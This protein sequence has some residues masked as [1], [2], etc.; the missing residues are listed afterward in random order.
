MV[1]SLKSFN[2]LNSSYSK[3]LR[4]LPF[5]EEP[6]KSHFSNYL[7]SMIENKDKNEEFIKKV[8]SDF[9]SKIFLV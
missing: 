3:N 9:L 8:I 5:H 7:N 2:E 6:F 1:V 4:V